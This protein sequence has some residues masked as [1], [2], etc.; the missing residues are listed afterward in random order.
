MQYI[1][2][3]G[4][5]SGIGHVTASHLISQGYH[6][7]GSVRSEADAQKCQEAFGAAFTPLVFDVRDVDAIQKAVDLVSATIQNQ[8]LTW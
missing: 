7:F 6:V 2:I 3:T 8:N 4:V 5:S 1:V